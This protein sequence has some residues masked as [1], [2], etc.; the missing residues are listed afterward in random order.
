MSNKELIALPIV[1]IATIL[2]FVALGKWIN[3]YF[4]LDIEL[5]LILFAFIYAISYVVYKIKHA[6]K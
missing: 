3:H 6:C 2:I 4:N 5:V 1:F